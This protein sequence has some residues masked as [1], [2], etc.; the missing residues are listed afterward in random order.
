MGSIKHHGRLGEGVNKRNISTG[1]CGEVA[2][3]VGLIFPSP[4]VNSC[5]YRL[6]YDI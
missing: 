1:G 5:L 6:V 4:A 2:K 3:S